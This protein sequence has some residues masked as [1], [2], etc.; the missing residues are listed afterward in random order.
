MSKYTSLANINA[1]YRY[2]V[3]LAGKVGMR[4]EFFEPTPGKQPYSTKSSI[5]I[6]L[7]S[8]MTEEAEAN[9]RFYVLHEC[10]H[11]GVG[12]AIFRIVEEQL[13]DMGHPLGIISNIIEDYRIENVCAHAF[14]GDR[15]IIDTG[16]VNLLASETAV[17]DKARAD[18]GDGFQFAADTARFAAIGA[19]TKAAMCEYLQAFACVFPDHLAQYPSGTVELVNILTSKNMQDYLSRLG[20]EY[21]TWEL[22]KLVYGWL[23]DKSPA[24]VE[25]EAKRTREGAKGEGKKPGENPGEGEGDGE[26]D[27][28]AG[29]GDVTGKKS[30][31]VEVPWQVFSSS[32][33]GASTDKG[34]VHPHSIDYGDSIGAHDWVPYPPER[35]EEIVP[36]KGTRGAYGTTV[37]SPAFKNKV[38]QWMQAKAAVAYDGG[39]KSGS[40]RA[41]QLWRGGVPAAGNAEWN[42]RVFKRPAYDTD[43]DSAVLLLIDYSGSMSGTKNQ[44]A[45]LAAAH[46]TEVLRCVQVPCAVL[47]FTDRS[48]CEILSFKKFSESP[49]EDELL[50]RLE[51]GCSHMCGNSDADAVL[52]ANRYLTDNIQAKRKV[53]IVL[54][55]GCP[56]DCME[57]DT[58]HVSNTDRAASG[59]KRVVSE[60]DTAFVT[61]KSNVEVIGIGIMDRNVEKFYKSHVVLDNPRDLE[62]TLLG[63]VK[64]S[65]V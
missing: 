16:R 9:L 52:Y 57:I 25:E 63:I 49:N 46:L 17:L 22:S 21:D 32:D 36:T 56:T 54:S 62:P 29:E 64:R 55:D 23:W 40:L 53:L 5:H 30:D 11:I 8:R 65:I 41:G 60:M 31:G 59:L 2:A 58:G 51:G 42:Q 18:H 15:A 14:K 19:V 35:V 3:Y 37:T 13:G 45:A 39:H 48:G 28:E 12:P 61:G 10:A 34:D 7:V 24:E 44:C 43:M 1:L 33:H 20:D 38:R 47:G 50:A 4:V 27:G 6:P 26:G